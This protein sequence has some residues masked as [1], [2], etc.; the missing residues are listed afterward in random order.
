MKINNA[1][2][3]LDGIDTSLLPKVFLKVPFYNLKKCVNAAM[4]A[5]GYVNAEESLP[6]IVNA[7]NCIRYG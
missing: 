4:T 1:D 2:C 5:H 3:S 7:L 6:I